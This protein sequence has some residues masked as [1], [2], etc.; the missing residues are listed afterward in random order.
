MDAGGTG[1]PCSAVS[2]WARRCAALSTPTTLIFDEI[3]G[4]CMF[5][6]VVDVILGRSRKAMSEVEK[7]RNDRKEP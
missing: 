7:S 4:I 1:W 3:D 5:L 6:P 2:P